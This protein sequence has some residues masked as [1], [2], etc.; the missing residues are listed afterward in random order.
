MTECG[1]FYHRLFTSSP[2]C[3]SRTPSKY[4]IPG[5]RAFSFLAMSGDSAAEG[6]TAFFA[7]HPTPLYFSRANKVEIDV[8]EQ[9]L[10][11]LET[12][13]SNERTARNRQFVQAAS[14][15]GARVHVAARHEK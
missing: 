3:F 15:A 10:G 9:L 1:A 4:V 5:Q 13:L 12:M 7:T 8:N 2:P 14:P 11:Y 6:V